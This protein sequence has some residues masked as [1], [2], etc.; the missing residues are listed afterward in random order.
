MGGGR[1]G[2]LQAAQAVREPLRRAAEAGRGR[3]EVGRGFQGEL[4]MEL[5][6]DVGDHA[7]SCLLLLVVVLVVGNLIFFI[8]TLALYS[9]P[10]MGGRGHKSWAR[11]TPQ[12][13]L[14]KHAVLCICSCPAI[15]TELGPE[16]CLAGVVGVGS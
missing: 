8:L 12:E 14:R 6:R 9:N 2:E 5:D 11:S 10:P 1:F 7:N 3:T 13:T 15:D 16:G 4:E